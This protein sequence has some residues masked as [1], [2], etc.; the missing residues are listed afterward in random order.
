MIDIHYILGVVNGQHSTG[1]STV[2]CRISE[3]MQL[4]FLEVVNGYVEIFSRGNQAVIAYLFHVVRIYVYVDKNC[5]SDFLRFATMKPRFC[6][7]FF[8]Y[9]IFLC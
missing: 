9:L 1:P 5:S 4:S 2:V 3:A 7:F 8:L 6:S